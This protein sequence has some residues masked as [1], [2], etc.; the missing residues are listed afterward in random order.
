[1]A[2][3]QGTPTIPP[4]RDSQSRVMRDS[5][6]IFGD[7]QRVDGAHANRYGW[8]PVHSPP[9]RGIMISVSPFP[10]SAVRE[11]RGSAGAHKTRKEFG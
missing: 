5:E 8:H 1:M 6:H 10:E 11:E 4:T 7:L 2:K 9:T 3:Y